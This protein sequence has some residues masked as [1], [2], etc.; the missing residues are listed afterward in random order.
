MQPTPDPAPTTSDSVAAEG[1]SEAS[2]RFSLHRLQDF[3]P[4]QVRFF[5]SASDAIS[6]RRPTDV[7]L[8]I[9]AAVALVALSLA[10]PGPNVLDDDAA[11]LVQN[12]PGLFG[13][14]WEL[15][16]DLLLFWGL[17]LLAA[18]L[19]SH[20]RKRLLLGELLAGAL[21]VMIAGTAGVIAGSDWSTNLR[22]IITTEP[23]V[24][25]PATRLALATAVIVAASPHLVR[26]LRYVGRWIVL[27]G[28]VAAIALGV[29]LPI[30]VMAAFAIGIAAAAVVHL[31]LGSPG[32]RL[33]LD[34]I[35]TALDDLGVEV[36]DVARAPLEPTG[37]ALAQATTA[38]GRT[39]EV[40]IYGRDA[41]DGQLLGSVWSSLW[42]RGETPNLGGRVQRVEHEAFVTLL[43]ERAGV[44][45]LPVVAA[46]LGAENDALLV[47]E[48]TGRPLASVDIE[49]IDDELLAHAWGTLAALHALG[50]A[51]GRVDG[52]RVVVRPD[53]TVALGDFG[54]STTAAPDSDLNIDNAQ[55]LVT[56]ALLVGVERAVSAAKTALGVGGLG[57]LPPYLQPAVLGRASRHE[58]RSR[59]WDLEDLREAASAASGIEP[60]KLEKIRRV[61]WSSIAVFALIGLLSYFLISAIAQIGF[62]TIITTFREADAVWLVAALCMSPT[63][64]VGQAVSTMGASI[65]PVRFGPVLMLQYAIQFIALAL[66][67][68]AAR[69]ALEIR[70]FQGYGVTPSGAVSISVLDSVCG[71][72][73]QVIV[74]IVTLLSGL[75][76]LNLAEPTSDSSGS[77]SDSSAGELLLIVGVLILC[78][79]LIAVAIP[80]YRR[81]IRERVSS[82]R[83]E[84][85]VALRVLRSPAKVLMIFLGQVSAQVLQAAVLGLCLKAFGYE[86]SL[87]SLILVNTLVSLFAGLMPVPG[88]VGVAEAAYTAGLIALGIPQAAALSTA[89]AFRAVTFYLPPIWG[90]F[91]MRWLRQRSF[92]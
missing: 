74:I 82:S 58:V 10:A 24:V 33:T 63:I 39:L 29:A 45:V 9:L 37:V 76:T 1:S 75:V 12:L 5:S 20:H 61:T 19:F 40:K 30:G 32:G 86:A 8:L 83:A 73:V 2:G 71:F 44:S 38:D 84:V 52:F 57:E 11:A 91:A 60:P 79:A 53:N 81:I 50:V 46:G 31:I 87:A 85:S 7:V 69:I 70:F 21:A 41:W 80:R 66:P 92:V 51:H 18:A 42:L 49:S 68:T 6:A 78:L 16:Y 25:Y 72:V 64:Q 62:Q 55:L 14:F 3:H 90:G 26:P 4:T 23:P 48:L 27:V 43:A 88:G 67:S 35:R 89:L 56:T 59:E 54:D 47:M 77:S 28:A 34:Q 36:T 15:S 22:G 65:R 13:W 17:F